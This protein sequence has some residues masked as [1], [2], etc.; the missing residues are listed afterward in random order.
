MLKIH[1]IYLKFF[2]LVKLLSNREVTLS[3]ENLGN[4]SYFEDWGLTLVAYEKVYFAKEPYCF[5]NRRPELSFKQGV[6][7][8]FAKVT[9]KHR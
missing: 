5:R 4:T 8:N 3:P 6:L 1:E 2:Y 7:E 9:G